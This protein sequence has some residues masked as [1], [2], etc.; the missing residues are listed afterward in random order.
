MSEVIE[1]RYKP[2]TAWLVMGILFFGG[3]SIWLAQRALSNDRGLI[4]NGA[5]HL[6]I[7]G[8]TIF[9]GILAMGSGGLAALAVLGLISSMMTKKVIRMTATEIH[10]P[11]GLFKKRIREVPFSEIAH[12]KK[13]QQYGQRFLELVH[14]QK[15][16]IITSACKMLT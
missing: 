9:Y 6:G 1:Y 3:G 16:V 10:I 15:T 14:G 2:S 7:Q 12:V 8:A 4:L 5:L 11:Q 13:Y